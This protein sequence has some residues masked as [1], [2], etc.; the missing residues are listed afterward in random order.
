MIVRLRGVSL[1]LQTS[2]WLKKKN[3]RPRPSK[4]GR[5][6]GPPT[7]PPYVWF[8]AAGTGNAFK[9]IEERVAVERRVL[10]ELVQAHFEL[11]RARARDE[12]HLNRALA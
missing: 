1:G 4:P 5:M 6:I 9:P 10:H 3:A 7:R 11:V 12:A 2:S 8:V